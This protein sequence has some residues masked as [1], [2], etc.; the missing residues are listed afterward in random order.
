MNAGQSG[1][2]SR[3]LIY[4]VSSKNYLTVDGSKVEGTGSRYSKYGMYSIVLQLLFCHLRKQ[5]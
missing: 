4:S 2:K 1:I 5:F 3:S